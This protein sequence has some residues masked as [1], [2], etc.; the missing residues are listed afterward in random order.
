MVGLTKSSA[1]CAYLLAAANADG[2]GIDESDSSAMPDSEDDET[3]TNVVRGVKGPIP[4]QCKKR[5]QVH[6]AQ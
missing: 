4:S 6:V 3:R 5:A 1:R 2:D